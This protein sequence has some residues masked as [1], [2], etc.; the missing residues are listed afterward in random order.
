MALYSYGLRRCSSRAVEG[1]HGN[2]M[3]DITVNIMVCIMVDMLFDI[4][5]GIMVNIIVD[6]NGR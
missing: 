5:V 1:I 4:V 6:N 2:P 3:I